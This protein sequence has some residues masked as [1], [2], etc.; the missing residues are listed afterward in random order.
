MSIFEE[1]GTFKPH[2]CCSVD[3]PVLW[4]ISVA[5][6]SPLFGIKVVETVASVS[7]PLK[8]Q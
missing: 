7:S 3:L 6:S 1:Y 5:V 2:S 4:A 8:N